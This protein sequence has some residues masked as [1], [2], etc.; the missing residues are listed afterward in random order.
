M[1]AGIAPQNILQVRHSANKVQIPCNNDE[2]I[3]LASRLMQMELH[4]LS[5]EFCQWRRRQSGV[6]MGLACSIKRMKLFILYLAR[7][8]Y[9]HQLSKAEVLSKC[10]AV[11]YLRQIS[12]FFA[13]TA[14]ELVCFSVY[15]ILNHFNKLTKSNRPN[16]I[17]WGP[18]NRQ[19]SFQ[20]SGH[21][22]PTAFSLQGL[23]NYRL[24]RGP[25][26]CPFPC[27]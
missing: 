9:Y 2:D 17:L 4:T 15:C 12:Q 24:L 16:K 5:A 23:P 19:S 7:G 18:H 3:Q 26:P 13:E 8:G 25:Y 21:Y 22:S 27:R 11:L 20:G 6:R 1:A 10:A 14:S